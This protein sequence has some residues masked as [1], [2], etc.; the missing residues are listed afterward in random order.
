MWKSKALVPDQLMFLYWKSFMQNWK[1]F[2]THMYC[3]YIY[4]AEKRAGS[5]RDMLICHTLQLTVYLFSESKVFNLSESYSDP[6]TGPV[7]HGHWIFMPKL[8]IYNLQMLEWYSWL[9]T[10]LQAGSR[11]FNSRWGHWD[12][13]LTEAFQSHYGPGVDSAS[14]RN[15]YQGYLLGG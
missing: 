4:F 14:N 10:A 3:R 7:C 5:R 2:V 6:F 13:S 1:S 11:R 15:E 8:I 12:F 9:S